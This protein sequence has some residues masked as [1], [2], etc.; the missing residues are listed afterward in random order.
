MAYMLIMYIT[1]STDSQRVLT[2]F[3]KVE[4]NIY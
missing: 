2:N 1:Y 4:N 3:K